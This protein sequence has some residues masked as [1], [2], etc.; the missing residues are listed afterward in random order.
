MVVRAH[1]GTLSRQA[2]IDGL[3]LVNNRLTLPCSGAPPSAP[4]SPAMWCASRW[5]AEQ[6]LFPAVLLLNNDDACVLLGWQDDGQTAR[7]IFPNW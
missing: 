3:P 6:R 4:A 7:V 1:G 2:A 5:M